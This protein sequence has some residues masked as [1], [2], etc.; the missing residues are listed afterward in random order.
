MKYL[1]TN[2]QSLRKQRKLT[3]VDVSRRTG[4]DVATLS[5]IENGRMTGTL[6]SH[7]AIAKALDVHLP[8]LYE[9]AMEAAE[10]PAKAERRSDAS[11]VFAHSGGSVSE[12][13]TSHVLQKKMM[14]V[15]L[16]LKAGSKTVVEEMPLGTERFLYVLSGKVDVVIKGASNAVAEGESLYFNASLPHFFSNKLKTPTSCLI[17]STPV[18]L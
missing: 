10:T 14:P 4:I 9:K 13:L 18:S 3:L 15:L 5:R 12:L 11:G 8:Q 6:Q 17:V 16:K 1:G 2:I 7:M